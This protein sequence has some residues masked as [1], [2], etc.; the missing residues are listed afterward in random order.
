MAQNESKSCTKPIRA[1]FQQVLGKKRKIKKKIK[2][3]K[4]KNNKKKNKK[5]KKGNKTK[6][7]EQQ[8]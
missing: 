8:G 3:K 1:M 5:N 7:K 6:D 4:R 2:K